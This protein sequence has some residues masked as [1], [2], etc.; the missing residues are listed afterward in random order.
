M[1]VRGQSEA[2]VC[3]VPECGGVH[4]A[5]GWCQKH[6][7]RW[8]KHGDPSI[9]LNARSGPCSISGCLGPTVGHGFCSKHY[10]RFKTHGDPMKVLYVRDHGG[11]CSSCGSGGPFYKGDTKCK[12]CRRKT[13]ERWR[14]INGDRQKRINAKFAVRKYRQNRKDAVTFYGGKCACCGE[15]EMVFLALDH[16]K[17]G[18]NAHRRS[19]SKNGKMVG[20]S[21]MYAWVVRNGFPSGFRVLCH[22][23]NFAEAHGGCPHKKRIEVA[24]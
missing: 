5:M 24:S 3:A 10:R 6:Y 9:N 1:A 14:L 18:G 22:N 2:R 16:E 20:S 13:H 15:S 23:C 21:T 4:S 19:L 7:I 12:K 17:G 8:K 11:K